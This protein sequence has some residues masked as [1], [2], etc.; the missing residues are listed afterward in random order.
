M[1]IR[2]IIAI[3]IY[4]STIIFSDTTIVAFE[5]VHQSFGNLGNNRTVVDTIQ[6]PQSNVG[7]SDIIMSVGLECPT[8]GCDPWDRKAKIDVMHL[9]QWFEIGR[10]VTP[11][12]VECGWEFDVTD[13]RSILQGE[14]ILRSHIDTWV[15]PGWLVNI[16]F[17]FI[18]GTP[19]YP[20]TSIRNVWNYSYIVYGDTTNPVNIPTINEYIPSDAEDVNLRMITTGHGQGNTDN[21]A[22]FSLK[23][24]DIF[25]NDELAYMHNF[26]RGD[27]E[28]NQCSPQNGTWQYDR[29]GFCPGDKVIPQDFGLLDFVYPGE[30]IKLDYILEDYFNYCSPNNPD[31]VN[32][33]TCTLCAY[34]NS[35]HT[36]PYYYIG[37]HL[38]MH[39]ETYHSNADVYILAQ[40]QDHSSQSINIYLENYVPVYG[41]QFTVDLNN[42]E[43]IENS[44]ISFGNCVGGRAEE[45]GWI[46]D[47]NDSGLVVGLVHGIG[48]PIPAGEGLLTQLTWNGGTFQQISGTISITDLEVSGYFGLEMSSE[49]GDP[50]EVEASLST[51]DSKILESYRVHAAYPNPFNPS[52]TIHYNIEKDQTIAIN[53]YDTMGRVV[54]NLFYGKQRKGYHELQWLADNNKGDL[55]G[56][57]VYFYTIESED[58]HKT[59]KIILLK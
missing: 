10:Y 47:V 17:D 45:S 13:Y 48:Q 37:S 25:L 30:T 52:T 1:I 56:S 7:F 23:I 22:E 36:E 6:L 40:D 21:A 29:A 31:C 24:H 18:L 38:I 34:N 2:Y 46:I 27:C 53:V 15:Q 51:E 16:S 20:F 35:G 55:I 12:G 14:V 44:E 42:L 41:M 9:N 39:T 57:G 28:Y 32:G 49:V 58:W 3:I 33:A 4:G 26:W 11:Y 19:E 54:K 5:S 50:L 43:G 8:G 59:E